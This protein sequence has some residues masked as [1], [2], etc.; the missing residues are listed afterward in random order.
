M[1]NPLFFGTFKETY[2]VYPVAMMIKQSSSKIEEM[3]RKGYIVMPPSA[4]SKLAHL[5]VELPMVFKIKNVE[6]NRCTHSGVIEFIAEEGKIF[7]PYW[8][9]E[10][11]LLDVGEI[12]TVSNVALPPGTY[13]KFEPQS[14]DFLEIAN[15][16]AVLEK[17]LRSF[18]CLSQG[19]LIALHYNN[20]VYN[21]KILETKPKDAVK[22]IEC[23]LQVEFSEPHGFQRETET[24]KL[25]DPPQIVSEPSEGNVFK[26][27]GRRLDGKTK[28]KKANLCLT[29]TI[30]P[31]SASK[32]KTNILKYK[33]GRLIFYP[34]EEIIAVNLLKE[35]TETENSI[36]EGIGRKLI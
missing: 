25:V 31:S 29:K 34:Y 26:G 35:T 28:V 36:F 7:M 8:M 1:F 30:L 32:P 11:L 18:S 24:P 14:L 9:M 33:K 2:S 3:E 16:K 23:D 19:D 6:K 22:I 27:T 10:N 21:V 13:A 4:L 15:P 17:S 12:A 5:E 20:R